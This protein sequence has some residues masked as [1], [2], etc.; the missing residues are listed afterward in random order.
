MPL[1]YRSCTFRYSRRRPP[2]ID[3]LD[4][5]FSPGNTVLLGPNGA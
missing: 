4:L 5:N 2:V 1:H 3:R